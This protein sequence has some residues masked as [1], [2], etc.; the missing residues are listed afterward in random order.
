MH[1]QPSLV[2]EFLLKPTM[3][4]R[5]RES[6][7][8]NKPLGERKEGHLFAFEIPSLLV[9]SGRPLTLAGSLSLHARRLFSFWVPHQKEVA[10]RKYHAE[11]HLYVSF[12]SFAIHSSKV[13]PENSAARRSKIHNRRLFYLW[14]DQRRNENDEAK[15][16]RRTLPINKGTNVGKDAVPNMSLSLHFISKAF[17]RDMCWN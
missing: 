14:I 3:V 13:A 1:A 15:F 7:E 10:H 11:K 4:R 8:K 17:S 9:W 5:V 12:V 6:K 2:Q 16:G